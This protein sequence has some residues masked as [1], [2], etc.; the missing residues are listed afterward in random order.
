MSRNIGIPGVSPPKAKE[1]C[2][3]ENC[4]F[5]GM[6][7]IRGRI[8][9]G[10]VVSKKSQ[11]TVVIRQDYLQFIK[12]YQRYERRNSKLACHLPECL[13][14]EINVGD[15]VRIGECR[16]ISKTKAFIVLEKLSSG[17]A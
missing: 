11:K 13:S 15:M 7:R 2:M 5:H 9:K 4:P 16:K 17:V 3:D 8:M 12:K 14:G 6:T 10:L 1:P